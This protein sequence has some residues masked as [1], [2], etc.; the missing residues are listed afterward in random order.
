MNLNYMAIVLCAILAMAMGAIWYGPLFGKMWLK[1]I[2]ATTLD[3]KAR[4]EMQKQAMPLYAIQFV[5]ALFQIWVF[6]WYIN[7]VPEYTGLTHAL[8]ILA[9][10]IVP[11]LA[12]TAMWN[13]N[14][15]KIK[16]T[17]FLL[18]SGYQ[19]ACFAVF[20]LILGWLK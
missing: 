5:L 8:W 13:N 7:T 15:N 19:F 6:A 20:G 12:G 10:F 4:K 3:L 1:T 14:S 16:L 11:T 9:A 18:Q 17:Q 2:G